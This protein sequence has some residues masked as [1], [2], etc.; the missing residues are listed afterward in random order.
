MDDNILRWLEDFKGIKSVLN[1][2][3]LSADSKMLKALPIE[4]L[5]KDGESGR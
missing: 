1:M 2:L 3:P 4:N 5:V